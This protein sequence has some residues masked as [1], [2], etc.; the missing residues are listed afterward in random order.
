MSEGR[1]LCGGSSRDIVAIDTNRI[2]DSCRDKDCYE[3][4]KV[5]LGSTGQDIIEH[6]GNV[7]VKYAEIVSANVSVEPVQF[8]RGFYTVNVRFYVK[9]VLE[10][11]IYPG[12]AQEFCGLS[13]IDKKVI[14]FGSEG[15]VNIYKSS[16]NCSFCSDKPFGCSHETNLPVGVIEVAAP[17][18]LGVKVLEH[19]HCCNCCCSV[20]DVPETVS[21]HFDCD[22]SDREDDRHL[23]ISLGFFSVVRIERPAQYLINATEYSIPKKECVQSEDD[24]PCSLFRNMDFPTAEFSPPSLSDYS[25]RVNDN[26]DGKCSC[27]GNGSKQV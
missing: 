12:K 24:D 7:R 8:S 18:V 16:E 25:S 19:K 26:P 27:R 17:V 20:E 3:D 6:T 9:I 22:F 1:S 2:L 23:V 15:N 5:Y 13:V 21:S 4:V 11:C 10:G 14:L